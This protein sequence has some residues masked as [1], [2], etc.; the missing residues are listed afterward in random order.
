MIG[1]RDKQLGRKAQFAVRFAGRLGSTLRLQFD[2][3]AISSNSARE[4]K[5]AYE[6]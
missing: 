5:K 4:S 6:D 1:L 3:L 2:I